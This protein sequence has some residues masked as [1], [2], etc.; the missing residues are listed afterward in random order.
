MKEVYV[1][2]TNSNELSRYCI[3]K[4]AKGDPTDL[5]R[6]SSCPSLSGMTEEEVDAEM[7]KRTYSAK[8]A[9][10]SANFILNLAMALGCGPNAEDGNTMADNDN[11]NNSSINQLPSLDRRRS[12]LPQ[13]LERRRSSLAQQLLSLAL[14]PQ[15]N[16]DSVPSKSE[17]GLQEVLAHFDAIRAPSFVLPFGDVVETDNETLSDD[18][19]DTSVYDDGHHT[20]DHNN[21][22]PNGNVVKDSSKQCYSPRTCSPIPDS[23][24]DM[25]DEPAENQEDE[26]EVS[27]L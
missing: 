15:I 22:I 6:S 11:N 5:H 8:E 26:T 13:N 20:K 3:S 24:I 17:M 12:S 1:T 18:V 2:Y 25:L 9:E 23:I 4:Q 7:S 21:P 16:R 19:D 27:K 10:D 14:M